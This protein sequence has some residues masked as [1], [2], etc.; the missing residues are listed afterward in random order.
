MDAGQP[1]RSAMSAA[2]ARGIHRIHDAPPWILDDPFALPL[3]GDGWQAF[4]EQS[5]ALSRPPYQA[6]SG[7]LLRARYPEDVLASGVY[8]QYVILGAGLDSF[9][10]RHPDFVRKGR[11][12]EV[13]HPATQTWKRERMRALALPASDRQVLVP[14]DLTG[15]TLD[16]SLTRAGF[17][18]SLPS[19]LSW[20]G[21]TMYLGPDAIG[22]TL[23]IVARCAAG[24]GIV[25]SYNPRPELLDD[26]H[27][28]VL[29]DV[30]RLVAGMGE[31]LRSAFAPDEIERLAATAGLQVAEA[32]SHADLERRY[33][34]GRPDGMRLL[35]IERLLW[36]R[37]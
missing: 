4:A 27:R 19:L 11:L 7:V 37:V 32:P 21:T 28:E 18:W 26:L 8:A 24:S 33:F 16:A 14:A 5:V 13:D 29:D 31:P 34:N 10:W 9:A 30:S 22:A 2:V 35:M 15:D 12:F 20:V 25:L 3:V 17:D 6:R 23:R 36:L 1:S